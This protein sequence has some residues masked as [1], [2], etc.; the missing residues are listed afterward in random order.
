MR[1]LNRRCEYSLQLCSFYFT[2]MAYVIRFMNG[3]WFEYMVHWI[4]SICV[5]LSYIVYSTKTIWFILWSKTMSLYR[6]KH[7]WWRQWTLRERWVLDQQQL[8]FSFRSSWGN[9]P[10]KWQLGRVV[11]FCAFVLVCH[12]NHSS[13]EKVPIMIM[14]E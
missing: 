8:C 10:G 2:K 7:Q 9:F 1:T 3:P 4:I 5:Y 14:L 13:V 11:E 6:L 12:R